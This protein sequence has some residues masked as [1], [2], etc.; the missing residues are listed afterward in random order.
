MWNPQP[1]NLN[2]IA[3]VESADAGSVR[4][5]DGGRSEHADGRPEDPRGGLHRLRA[6]TPHPLRQGCAG[7]HAQGEATS[8]SAEFSYFVVCFC[9]GVLLNLR[10][11][12]GC[13]GGKK[14]THSTSQVVQF[15]PVSVPFSTLPRTTIVLQVFVV[16]DD[17]EVRKIVRC[18]NCVEDRL[19]IT[20]AVKS[21]KHLVPAFKVCLECFLEA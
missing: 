19:A 15:V 17:A 21:M 12:I 9:C 5:A 18:A 8:C 14:C 4:V 11:H 16:T 1:I 13:S 3:A 20:T 10:K 6:Q 7:S 2:C